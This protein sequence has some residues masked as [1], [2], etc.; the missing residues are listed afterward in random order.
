[1]TSRSTSYAE[2]MI[3]KIRARFQEVPEHRAPQAS[4]PLDDALMSAYA[5]FSLKFPSLLEFEEERRERKATSSNLRTV[6]QIGKVP[7]DTQMREIVDEV[8][9]EQI[10]DIFP[11]IFHWIQKKKLLKPYA[12]NKHKGEDHFLLS[13]DGTGFFGS[14]E[15][16]CEACL[17][18][19]KS[20]SDELRY[21]HQMLTAVMV[22]PDLKTVIPMAPEAI[23]KQDGES[24]N[25][26][27]MNALKRW[28]QHFREQH[29]R[30]KVILN[31]DGLYGNNKIISLLRGAQIPFII[32]VS[33]T[34]QTGL[35]NY[36]EGAEQRGNVLLYTWQENFG[37]K[38]EKT[39]TCHFRFKVDCPLNGQEDPEWVNFFEYWEEVNWT[40]SKGEQQQERYHCAWVTDLSCKGLRHAKHLVKGARSR[41]KVENEG[42]NTLKNQGY[43]LEHNYGHGKTHLAENFILLMLLAF[44]VDQIQLMGCR[45]FAKIMEVVK[46]KTRVWKELR[47][48]YCMFKLQSWTHLLTVAFQMITGEGLELDS[49]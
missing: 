18:R 43:N 7:S 41:W 37:E 14:N 16:N 28:V 17:T 36:I 20:D 23:V 32:V 29:P 2:E 19:K 8:A 24:K 1:M 21:H 40:N 26:C 31:L 47:S 45:L 5:M 33:E 39:K 4:I 10:Q 9:P 35:F 48:I 15:I 22:H 13:V 38:V 44:L 12:F 34:L 3:L 27:E 46:R 42:H 11:E 6:Y 25:D 49:S 30:L